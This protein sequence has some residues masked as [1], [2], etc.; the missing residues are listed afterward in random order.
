MSDMPD[1]ENMSPEEINRWLETLAKRQGASEGLTTA[2]DMEIAEVDPDTVVI[3]EPGYIPYGQESTQATRAVQATPTPPAAESRPAERVEP[4]QQPRPQAVTPPPPPPTQL[5]QTPAQPP[6]QPSVQPPAQSPIQPAARAPE[7]QSPPPQTPPAPTW[8]PVEQP[9][10]QVV[11]PEP[12]AQEGSLAWLASLAAQ[13]NDDMF[14]FDLSEFST[15]VTET[16]PAEPETQTSAPSTE[17]VNPMTWLE[18][19]ARE[20][21]AE[22]SL[23]RLG[24]DDDEVEESEKINPYTQNVDP[25]AWLETLAKRQ[26]AKPEELTTRANVN[27]PATDEREV[28]QP[29][30]EPFSFD[31]PPTRRVPEPVD[32]VDWLSS[33]AGGEGYSEEGVLATQPTNAEDEEPEAEDM[34]MAAIQDAIANGTV[35]RDQMQYFLEQQADEIAEQP[36]ETFTIDEEDEEL[37]PAELPD[38]L[39]ELQ[40]PP[41]EPAAAPTKPLDALFETPAV[42]EMPDWLRSDLAGDEMGGLESIFEPEESASPFVSEQEEA[43]L[44]YD[45]QVDANDPW[46]EAFE[47]EYEQG[48]VS[49]IDT[50]PAWYEENLHDPSRLAAVEGQLEAEAEAESE[51]VSAQ[52]SM[53]LDS[54]PLPLEN[55]LTAGQPEALPSWIILDESLEVPPVEEAQYE[56]Y[57]EPAPAPVSEDFGDE[58]VEEIPDWL[59]ELESVSPQ[60]VPDW[61]VETISESNAKAAAEADVIEPA[62]EIITP[63]EPEP[64]PAPLVV[65]QPRAQVYTPP[66]PPPQPRVASGETM[67]VIERARDREQSGDLEGA[68]AEYE[69][70][71]RSGG[72]LDTV[73]AD[74]TQL[75]KSYKTTPAVFR[76]LGDG[77]MRQGK[78]QAALNT[79]REALNQL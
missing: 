22:P 57:E 53:P 30:Y 61:L 77:L 72:D 18:D 66:T 10:P 59:K 67:V 1:F 12:A 27:I 9:R 24:A 48:G 41:A 43:E 69:S 63:P 33:L 79:Y 46:V 56:A 5:P 4:T 51:V 8:T 54:T 21:V 17:A 7:P 23:E 16:P 35:T 60:S 49:D 50:V 28:E 13:Q 37:H 11:A 19:L 34:S 76:V 15:E 26:G 29:G 62:A 42:P 52:D 38:W 44:G 20:Q 32:T 71:V 74:L 36:E 55:D 14:N 25:M 58:V 73:V 64:E 70:L 40:P 47:T 65:E 68:L 6:A 45:I 75:T 2:A 31:T 3:D 39:T 78:L